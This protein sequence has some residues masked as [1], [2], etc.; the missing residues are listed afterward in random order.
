MDKVEKYTFGQG[1]KS[2]IL[3]LRDNSG[4]L[5][6]IAADIL[7]QLVPV[8]NVELFSTINREGKKKSFNSLG[9]PFFKLDK[10]I[11]LINEHT[12]SSAE[13]IA[14]SLQE[15]K[16]AKLLGFPSFGKATV[17][18]PFN[19]ADGSQILFTTFTNSASFQSVY[20]KTLLY[21]QQRFHHQLD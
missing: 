17:L 16:L 3:D 4:G 19:L 5:L 11:I 20:P 7:N 21:L 12:A 14:G 1:R 9:K 2:L 15:L 8:R 6:N 18:E 10:I 13:I